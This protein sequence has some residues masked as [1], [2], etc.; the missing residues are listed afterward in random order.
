M[1]SQVGGKF[2]FGLVAGGLLSLAFL[3]FFTVM[4]IDETTISMF[5]VMILFLVTPF[6]A[7]KGLDDEPFNTL[8]RKVFNVSLTT[9]IV[10]VLAIIMGI[11]NNLV[12]S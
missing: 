12:P 6:V 2:P 7:H 5:I 10:T 11:M 8:T 3:M 9:A 4:W 1:S